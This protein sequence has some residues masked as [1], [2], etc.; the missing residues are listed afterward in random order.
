V[1]RKKGYSKTRNVISL[2]GLMVIAVALLLGWNYT[3]RTKVENSYASSSQIYSGTYLQGWQDNITNLTTFES[4]IGKNVS[5]LNWFIAWG[6]TYRDFQTRNMDIAR[7]HGSIPLITWEPWD[8]AAGKVQSTYTLKSIINGNHDAYITKWALAAKSWKYPFFLRLA[9]EMDGDWYPWSE[10]INTNTSGEYVL[11]WRHIHDI[12][13]NNGVTNAT[14]V[15]C[16]YVSTDKS[17]PL[18]GLYPGDA[19]VDWT[20]LDGYNWGTSQ[21]WSAWQSFDTIFGTQYNNILS[22]APVKPMMIAETGVVENGGSKPDWFRDAL[23]VQIPQNYPKVSAFVYFNRPST[24]SEPDWRIE[25]TSASLAAFR[26]AI[27]SPYYLSNT[28]GSITTSP[29]MPVYGNVSST[30]P[31]ITST[32]PTNTSSPT[33]T[34]TKVPTPN[35]TTMP[36]TSIPTPTTITG[37][38]G[39]V[40][41]YYANKTLSGSSVYTRIDPQINFSW[42]NGS[43]SSL[44]PKDSFSVR[45]SGYLLPQYSENYTFYINVNDGARV[46]VNNQLLING[47][48]DRST[49]VELTGITNLVQ[50][51]KVPVVIE[52]YDNTDAALVQLRWSSLHQSK[53]LVPQSKLFTD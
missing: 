41:N 40:G 36:T 21:S 45:W 34:V 30:T 12:F 3:N 28:F 43:P 29:I 53:Q 31:T 20:C 1:K 10:K 18:S 9:H 33:S 42:K 16:P 15:W 38:N 22:I 11:A 5:I 23:T 4:N 52:F 35:L 32:I 27:A 13:A 19:Y 17:I 39:L 26:E 24:G 2:G 25:T 8:S 46:W 49:S 6:D 47:W 37:K 14:W 48:Q 7:Q 44:V 50:N 51:Q